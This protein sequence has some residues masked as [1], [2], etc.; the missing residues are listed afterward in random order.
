MLAAGIC[1][2]LGEAS[3]ISFDLREQQNDRANNLLNIGL[4]GSRGYWPIFLRAGSDE[5]IP[6]SEVY[7]STATRSRTHGNLA[8]LRSR[9]PCSR[10]ARN[11]AASVGSSRPRSRPPA[12]R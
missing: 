4:Q 5:V 6:A 10:W 7:A 1:Y 12:C 2:S 11:A 8:V 3:C 9:N